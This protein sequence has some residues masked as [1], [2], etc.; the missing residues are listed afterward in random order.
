MSHR[1]DRG[2]RTL[3]K[4][5]APTAFGGFLVGLCAASSQLLFIA[6]L[7]SIEGQAAV[8]PPVDTGSAGPGDG[9][10]QAELLCA[11]LCVS[12]ADAG[13]TWAV[14][15]ITCLWLDLCLLPCSQLL[16]RRAGQ[17]SIWAA[18]PL[19]D[20]AG[21]Q[22]SGTCAAL[23]HYLLGSPAPEQDCVRGSLWRWS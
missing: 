10:R 12:W 5:I 20:C 18:V 6:G 2:A 3:S 8:L 7:C 22:Q 21:A 23:G 11:F 16:R 15:C 17:L 13:P 19:G 1:R 4:A 14:G 9:A